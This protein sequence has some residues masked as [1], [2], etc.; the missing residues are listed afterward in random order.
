MTNRY[1]LPINETKKR[2]KKQKNANDEIKVNENENAIIGKFISDH[3]CKVREIITN[4]L[5][6]IEDNSK[7]NLFSKNELNQCIFSLNELYTKICYFEIN[8]NTTKKTQDN[9]INIL[10]DTIN[11]VTPIIS[12]YGTKHMKDIIYI[13]FGSDLQS[14]TTKSII[15]NDKFELIK[16][17]IH[18]TGFKQITTKYNHDTNIDIEPV[19]LNKITEE[20]V[21]IETSPQFECF[22][23]DINTNHFFEKIYG[24]QTIIHN[25]KTGKS[26]II[27][28]WVDN[29][30]ITFF[31]KVLPK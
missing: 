1:I 27:K 23:V 28:G 19:C 7:Y 5:I 18:P 22:D 13:C 4:T 6:S 17:Y 16:K 24:I 20:V 8:E 29:I 31:S 25:I 26:I 14:L 2:N 15:L 11:Q 30:N 12:K 3:L 9:I 21:V 10:Q